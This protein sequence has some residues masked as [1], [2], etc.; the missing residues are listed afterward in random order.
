MSKCDLSLHL[1]R[2]DATFRAGEVIRGQVRAQP[3]EAVECRA[4]N[5]T[6]RWRT[7][8]RGNKDEGPPRTLTLFQGQWSAGTPQVYPFEMP[9]PAGPATYHGQYVNVDHYLTATADLPWSLDPK[10]EVEILLAASDRPDYD[11]GPKY[12]PSAVENRASASAAVVG[13]VLVF[14]CF[15]LP[16]LIGAAL[17]IPAVL[18]GTFPIWGL[19]VPTLF[20]AVGVGLAFLLLKSKLA[21]RRLGEPRVKIEPDPARPGDAVTVQIILE[22]KT[23]LTLTEGHVELK[24]RE[25]AV[26][27]SGTNRTTH[28]TDVYSAKA[29]LPLARRTLG[30]GQPLVLQESLTLPADAGPTFVASDNELKWGVTVA[31]GIDGWPDWEGTFP[32]TVRP[33]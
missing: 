10:A 15:G 31:I 25:S 32:L 9:A 17:S 3:S 33:R 14:S 18:K 8:G 20:A 6:L 11:F 24:G 27:G 12:K 29:P 19:I 26:S 16:G 7:H 4:L 13:A 22:P 28:S 5:L 1:E 2:A 23:A 21:A 30:P